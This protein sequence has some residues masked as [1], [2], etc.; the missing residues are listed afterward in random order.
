MTAPPSVAASSGASR[1]TATLTPQL[2]T[3]ANMTELSA[4]V[5]AD[6]PFA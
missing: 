2:S 3:K 5:G 6:D 4:V 1:S